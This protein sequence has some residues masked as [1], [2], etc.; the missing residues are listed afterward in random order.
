[1]DYYY[2][3]LTQFGNGKIGGKKQLSSSFQI[4]LIA[5]I[6]RVQP[7]ATTPSVNYNL[8]RPIEGIHGELQ[9]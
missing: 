6:S 2:I 8:C 1:M 3:M 9:Q 5:E 4:A 7:P